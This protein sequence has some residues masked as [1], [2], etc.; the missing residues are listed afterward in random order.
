VLQI[1]R[2]RAQLTGTSMTSAEKY[3]K[4]LPSIDALNRP[5]WDNAKA[6]RFV[7]QACTK[8][9]HVSYPPNPICPKCLSTELEWRQASG[10]GTLKSWAVFHRAYWP[11]FESEVPYT[12]CLVRLE[13]GPLF[14]ANFAKGMK[15]EPKVGAKVRVVFEPVTPEI[16]LPQFS[17]D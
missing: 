17:V 2:L 10:K 15:S 11:A 5:F 6:G 13:E 7:L 12:V 14:I 8:C 3:S 1:N 9:G 4:P 16:T